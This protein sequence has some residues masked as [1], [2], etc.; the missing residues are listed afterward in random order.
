MRLHRNYLFSAEKYCLSTEKTS[1]ENLLPTSVKTLASLQKIFY[2][3]MFFPIMT[4]L[5]NKQ[6]STK[7][8]N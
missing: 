8:K 7:K 5:L 1:A 4:F 3:S 6:Y 2:V